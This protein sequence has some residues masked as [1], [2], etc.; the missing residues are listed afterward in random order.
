MAHTVTLK[1]SLSELRDKAINEIYKYGQVN[2]VPDNFKRIYHLQRGDNNLDKAL[3]MDYSKT[4]FSDLQNMMSEYLQNVT[5]VNEGITLDGGSGGGIF[6][7]L[8]LLMPGG[9]NEHTKQDLFT[10]C[11]QYILNGMVADWFGNVRETEIA[12]QFTKNATLHSEM[13]TKNIY[14]KNVTL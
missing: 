3:L 13:I 2:V 14:T 11:E 6:D 5:Q 4:R 7:I 1:F 12:N 8:T 9:W 10:H